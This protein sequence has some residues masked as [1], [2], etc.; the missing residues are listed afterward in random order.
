VLSDSRYLPFFTHMYDFTEHVQDTLLNQSATPEILAFELALDD[1]LNVLL[2]NR[3][4]LLVL[5][6]EYSVILQVDLV[7]NED[8]GH[9]GIRFV[10]FLILLNQL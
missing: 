3:C 4:V 1:A 7:A 9:I 8:L 10:Q 5:I 6:I 2:F